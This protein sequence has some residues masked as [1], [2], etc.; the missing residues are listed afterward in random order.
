M[1]QI[2]PLLF[3]TSDPSLIKIA[4]SGGI[5]PKTFFENLDRIVNI[6]TV[7]NLSKNDYSFKIINSD[8]NLGV[9]YIK[10]EFN[11]TFMNKPEVSLQLNLIPEILVENEI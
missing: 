6:T 3:Q 10:F 5:P 9:F 8:E 1:F 4:F 2:K 11:R 7:G